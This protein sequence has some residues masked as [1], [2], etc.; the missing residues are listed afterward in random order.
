MNSGHPKTGSARPATGRRSKRTQSSHESA[1]LAAFASGLGFDHLPA[2]VVTRGVELFVDWAGSALSG[3]GQRPI[4]ILERFAA[5][6]GPPTGPAEILTARR[7][8]SPL[9][10]ALVN[11]GA[12]HISEQD[13]DTLR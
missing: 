11:A 3:K 10:A 7:M 9:F 13:D 1:D 4:A 12:S 5:A 8:T 6:M 2:P